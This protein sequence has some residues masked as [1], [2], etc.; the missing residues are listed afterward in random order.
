MAHLRRVAQRLVDKHLAALA[1][2][3]HT[4][5][6]RS[7]VEHGGVF[8]ES[9]IGC[10]ALRAVGAD[11]VPQLQRQ[12]TFGVLPLLIL[13]VDP[14]H[15]AAVPQPDPENARIN[16]L[17]HAPAAVEHLVLFG[18]DAKHDFVVH[19]EF[20]TFLRLQAVHRSEQ[21]ARANVPGRLARRVRQA[22]ELAHRG[23]VGRHDQVLLAGVRL[24]AAQP[25]VDQLLLGRLGA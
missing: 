6:R 1:V 2:A 15:S 18:V 8:E 25:D 11:A 24:L 13:R 7:A 22:V 23:I 3:R 10:Q 20:D 16:P 5:A 17:D 19:R 4:H 12:A 9:E 14:D 21:Q